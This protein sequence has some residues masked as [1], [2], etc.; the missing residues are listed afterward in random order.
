MPLDGWKTE[1]RLN[2]PITPEQ[3]DLLTDVDFDHTDRIWF[4]TKHDK[5]VTFVKERKGKWIRLDMHAHLADHICTACGEAVYVPTCGGVPLYGYCPNC[6]A[7]MRG[8]E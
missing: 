4:H 1:L 2:N 7:D 5:D 3:W 8:E 6:G